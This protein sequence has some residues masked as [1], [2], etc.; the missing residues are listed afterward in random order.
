[1]NNYMNNYNK[2]PLTLVN[3]SRLLPAP[4]ACHPSALACSQVS[5][6]LLKRPK[7]S[8]IPLP[9]SDSRGGGP[10]GGDG[11]CTPGAAY[12]LGA[13][14]AAGGGGGAGCEVQ[15]ADLKQGLGLSLFGKFS[16]SS[17]DTAKAMWREAAQELAELAIQVRGG[18]MGGGGGGGTKG[19]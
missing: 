19:G 6:V 1:M 13:A 9:I 18:V 4:L 11:G 8:I 12:T 7:N 14:A 10:R 3:D 5:F 17:P 15:G 2:R 16:V